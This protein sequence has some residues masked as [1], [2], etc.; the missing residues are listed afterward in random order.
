MGP[1]PGF[2][3]LKLWIVKLVNRSPWQ[4]SRSGFICTCYGTSAWR[5]STFLTANLSSICTTNRFLQMPSLGFYNP[6]RLR[7]SGQSSWPQIQ[8]S[9]FD[10]RRC[11]FFWEVVWNGVHSVSWV[12][13]R[14]CL[15]SSGSSLEIRDYG[16]RGSAAL[17]TRHPSIGK[18]WH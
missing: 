18:S 7:S 11:Q 17:T 9:G 3:G 4:V 1:T 8:R 14:S 12:Q 6:V 10:S 2:V 16:R 5:R 15:K 13:L